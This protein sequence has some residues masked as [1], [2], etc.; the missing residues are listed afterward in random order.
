MPEKPPVIRHYSGSD[1]SMLEKVSVIHGL[2]T[3]DLADF[4]AFDADF[5]ADYR[6][7]WQDD[8]EAAQS[9]TSD[10]TIQDQLA[11][12]TED[13]ET[14]M[15]L[16]RDKWTEVKYF[17]NK[18]FPDSRG[19]L[20]EF[21]ADDYRAASGSQRLMIPFMRQLHAAA[22]KYHTQLIAKSYTQGQID[23]IETLQLALFTANNVQEQF[24]KSRLGLT[25]ERINVLNKP[26]DRVAQVNEAAQIIYIN[27][28]AKRAEYTFDPHS[29]GGGGGGTTYTG[30]VAPLETKTIATVVYGA[31][32]AVRLGN[33]GS[34]ELEF[35]LRVVE[36][37][38]G[39]SSVNLA[40]GASQDLTMGDMNDNPS[41][42]FLVVE[43]MAEAVGAYSVVMG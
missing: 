6:D 9:L 26:Y 2:F 3:T 41:A 17:A 10:E 7:D 36:G 40:S 33:T 25:E 5:D 43:N 22:E 35:S 28:A 30:T 32:T 11:Q 21:G 20:H 42:T 4:T 34:T 27:S 16:A 19:K 18:A 14:A 31:G 38:S 29:G 23:E 15:G 39:G 8:I 12:L 13:V 37:A 24:K 1:P